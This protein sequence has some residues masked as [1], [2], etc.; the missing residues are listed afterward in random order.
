[1]Y[2]DA[3]VA[4]HFLFFTKPAE[5]IPGI[6][7]EE[8]SEDIFAPFLEISKATGGLAESS[9]NPQFLF[10]KAVEASEN[11]YLVYYSPSNYRRDGEFKSI[12]VKV[13]GKN[14]RVT[15]RAGYFAN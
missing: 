14:Y 4:I 3:S 12:K 9:S 5:Y 10:E 6:Y 7:F 11:Y 2:A 8:H 15:H 13:R 1:A